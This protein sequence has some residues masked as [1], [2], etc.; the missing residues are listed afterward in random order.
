MAIGAEGTPGLATM[1]IDRLA[2]APRFEL[3]EV[4]TLGPDVM[5]RWR[6]GV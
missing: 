6:A 2:E 5:T 1:G 3:A 4:K